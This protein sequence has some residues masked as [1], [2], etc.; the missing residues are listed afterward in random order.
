VKDAEL[1]AVDAEVIFSI[2]GATTRRGGHEAAREMVRIYNDWRVRL[3]DEPG[4]HP[5][6]RRPPCFV[7]LYCRA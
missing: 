4:Q 5:R 3:P 7:R 6:C 1:D 2:L